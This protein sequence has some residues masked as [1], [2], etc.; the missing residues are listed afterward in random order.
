MKTVTVMQCFALLG[1][2]PESKVSWSVGSRV[3]AMWREEHGEEPRKELRAKTHGAGTHCMAV[4]PQSWRK[5]IER[6]IKESSEM[7]AMQA[8]MFGGGA[9]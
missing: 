4:Y 7:Y 1:I 6:V 2:V 8:D 5:R 9:S 3:A